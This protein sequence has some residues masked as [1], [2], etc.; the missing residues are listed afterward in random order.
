MGMLVDVYKLMAALNQELD[1]RIIKFGTFTEQC[2]QTDRIALLT[3]DELVTALIM[4]GKLV[5][6]N[7]VSNELL[8]WLAS[9][10]FTKQAIKNDVEKQQAKEYKLQ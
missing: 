1:K 10:V 2:N 9:G 3:D 8:S 4:I 6:I 5:A 7:T